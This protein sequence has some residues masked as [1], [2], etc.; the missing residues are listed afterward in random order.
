MTAETYVAGEVLRE[1]DLEANSSLSQS[2]YHYTG[3]S[4][5]VGIIETKALWLTHIRFLNDITEFRTMLKVAEAAL[6]AY[7]GGEKAKIIGMLKSQLLKDL[8]ATAVCVCSLSTKRDDLSQWRAYSHGDVGYSI[9]FRTEKL[10]KL[11]EQSSAFLMKCVYDEEAQ[12]AIIHRGIDKSIEHFVTSPVILYESLKH[13][14]CTLGS[15]CKDKSFKDEAEV[16]LVYPNTMQVSKSPLFFR[17]SNTSPIPY[18][19]LSLGDKNVDENVEEIIC[20]PTPDP[21]LS[22]LGA[23]ILLA[24]N[25]KSNTRLEPSPLVKRSSIPFRNWQ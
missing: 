25:S 3:P 18:C 1:F 8:Q 12:I 22:E 16:R 6:D 14:L 19:K 9:G 7:A 13:T 5:I 4:G 2:L 23:S 11:C 15:M 17:T 10:K 20:G 24:C 21:E